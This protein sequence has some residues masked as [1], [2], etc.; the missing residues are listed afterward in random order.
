M[1]IL[2]LLALIQSFLGY[3]QSSHL[4]LME[5]TPRCLEVA[6]LRLHRRNLTGP[7][8]LSMLHLQYCQRVSTLGGLSR[9]R[10]GVPGLRMRMTCWNSM[11][12][13][14]FSSSPHRP[15][16]SGWYGLIEGSQI[17]LLHFPP[18][19]PG[20]QHIV[21]NWPISNLI[22]RMMLPLCEPC[23]RPTLFPTPNVSQLHH[24]KTSSCAM[25]VRCLTCVRFPT[26]RPHL[27]FPIVYLS[28]ARLRTPTLGIAR[29]PHVVGLIHSVPNRHGCLTRKVHI[30]RYL[31]VHPLSL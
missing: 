3:S 23:Q 13:Q 29:I 21:A 14:P 30:E 10:R 9:L 12:N 26:F 20:G 11:P 15:F 7:T 25:S 1:Q 24:V 28:L 18:R 22:L 17:R 27:L 6:P 4:D 5:A 8:F 2:L 19:I 16:N 31:Y